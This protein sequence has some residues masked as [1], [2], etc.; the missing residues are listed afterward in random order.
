MVSGNSIS[1]IANGYLLIQ[2][3]PID[4]GWLAHYLQSDSEC[5]YH[6]GL[7]HRKR[8]I[9][10]V[11]N[12]DLSSGQLPSTHMTSEFRVLILEDS[13]AWCIMLCTQKLSMSSSL[14]ARSCLSLF[15]SLQS[16]L[17][18][19][20]SSSAGRKLPPQFELNFFSTEVYDVFKNIYYSKL[21][22]SSSGQSRVKE[23]CVVCR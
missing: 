17:Y 3:K 4:Y 23:D 6:Q 15:Y 22:I 11:K 5:S 16:T 2:G 19:H 1:F 21:S 8:I 20:G 18:H 14:A 7:I 13:G 9:E 12:A 10:N